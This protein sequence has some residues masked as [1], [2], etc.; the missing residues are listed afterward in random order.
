MSQEFSQE[1]AFID[2]LFE[3]GAAIGPNNGI[4]GL[5]QATIDAIN[6]NN[7]LDSQGDIQTFD[8]NDEYSDSELM[9]SDTTSGQNFIDYLKSLSGGVVDLGKDIASRAILSKALA[10]AGSMIN[11]IVGLGSGIIGLLKGGNLFN[12]N[13]A[14]A[15]IAQPGNPMG[16]NMRRD[17]ASL[18]RMLNRLSQN[19]PIGENRLTNIQNKFGLENIDTSGM[20]KSI[21]ESAQTGYGGYGSAEAASA[22][23]A[24]GGRDYSESPGAMEGDM[25]YGEE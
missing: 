13:S 10:G 8:V 20:A 5:D 9:E 1:K 12:R 14:I 6:L 19:K 7:V 11:P 24:S 22:A 3:G 25:E 15:D 17:A 21:A 23:A 2:A 16:L 4:R 18:S